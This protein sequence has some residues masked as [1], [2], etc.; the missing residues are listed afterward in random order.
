MPSPKRVDLD[1]HYARLPDNA[2][3]HLTA[4]RELCRKGLPKAEEAL[5]W[6]NPAFLQDG[7]R[8]LASAAVV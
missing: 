5:Q 4:L 6:S 8:L 2:T 7:V 3:A 1:D